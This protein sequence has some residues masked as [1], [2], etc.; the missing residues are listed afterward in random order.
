M[1]FLLAIPPALD[2][3][4]GDLLEYAI[5][6]TQSVC[7]LN[8]TAQI[9]V[10]IVSSKL[11]KMKNMTVHIKCQI[12][13]WYAL[14]R[15]IFGELVFCDLSYLN[16]NIQSLI[17]FDG[18]SDS[19]SEDEITTHLNKLRSRITEICEKIANG[20]NTNY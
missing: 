7:V 8:K 4:I 12:L 11:E 5:E 14:K 6:K 13:V 10:P 9:Y 20:F 16:L 17:K 15:L 19:D 2:I 18:N 1:K 3:L